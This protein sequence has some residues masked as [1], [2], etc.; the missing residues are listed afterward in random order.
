MY[1]YICLYIYIYNYIC[2]YIYHIY[3][4]IMHFFWIIPSFPENIH[5][6]HGATRS[7]GDRHRGCHGFDH[8]GGAQS[9]GL[10][11][12]R[13]TGGAAVSAV[14]ELDLFRFGGGKTVD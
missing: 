3:I 7:F 2:L 11:L 5:D 6:S 14:V 4:Y 12:Q 10:V 1:I 13:G 9:S 8:H